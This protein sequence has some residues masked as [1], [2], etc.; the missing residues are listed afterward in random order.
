[1][2]I[3]LWSGPAMN[4]RKAKISWE[5]VC[6]TKQE[7]G[8]G[9]RPLKEVNQVCCLKLIWRIVSASSLWV[10]WIKLYLIRKDSI[11]TIKDN[12][13]SGSWMWRKIL[14]CRE[15]AKQFYRVEVHNGKNTSFWHEKWT[16]L[17]C[18][19]DI[20]REGSCI[21]IGIP[22]HAKVEDSPNHRRKHHRVEIFNRIEMEIERF[23]ENWVQEEDLSL[24]KNEKGKV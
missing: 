1:M 5:E 13:Q 11:W 3:F 20:V 10:S 16:S 15:K 21:D 22:I 17:G 14:H 4:G 23:K 18:L 2:F 24:W 9:L 6:K 7:G 19:K 8:L 12:T